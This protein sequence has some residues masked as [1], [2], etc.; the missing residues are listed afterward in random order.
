MTFCIYLTHPQV[1][2]DPEVPVPDWGLSELGR[3]RAEAAVQLPWA[4][5]IRHVISSA[6]RK[7]IET[8]EIFV[9]SFG[10][11]VTP[12]EVLHEND[13]SATG[14]LPP[15]EFE[16]VA[17]QFF[18]HPDQSVRGWETAHGAQ[19]RIVSGISACLADIE[20]T[21]P[22]L[23]TGHGGVG[24]LLK[25]HLMNVPISRSHDQS[26][27]GGCWYRFEKSDLLKQTATGLSWERLS[28][29]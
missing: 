21:E 12:I 28:T 26:G 19:E 20:E 7:A 15:D 6:E 1:Q 17:D 27:G 4:A 24:T 8:G 29:E 3:Q 16:Q 18:A 9:R 5:S 10:L 13:R 23:F 25:C 2:I 14:F 11:P 22:V